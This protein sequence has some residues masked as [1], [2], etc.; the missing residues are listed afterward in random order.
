M[1]LRFKKLKKNCAK[2]NVYVS[3]LSILMVVVISVSFC[4]SSTAKKERNE[5]Q[6]PVSSG[7]SSSFDSAS[8]GA[9]NK[10]IINTDSGDSFPYDLNKPDE[11]Y[12]LPKYLTEISGIAYYKEN[13]ILCEQDQN[14]DI[15]VFNLN[16]KEIVNKYNFG[17]NGDY[18][19]IAVVGKTVYILRSDGKI[20][21]VEEFDSENRKVTEH[22]TPLSNNNNT[23]GLAYDKSSSSLLIA[24]K[25]SPAIYKKNQYSG[26][27]AIYRFDLGKMKLREEP[28]FLIDL[29]RPE[30]YMNEKIFKK[31]SGRSDLSYKLLR[32]STSLMPSGLT[33]HPFSDEIYLISSVGKILVV[34]NR[35][36]K[37]LDFQDL[38][39][40]IFV[41]PEGICFSPEGDL[42]I[43]SE[44]KGGQGYILKFKLKK[45]N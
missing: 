3:T 1:I 6:E 12:F 19:D 10:G 36:G 18:E 29:A 45:T 33:F 7:S 23:E 17:K 44:G 31:Y 41:Q 20:F 14:A 27:R 4:N 5:H 40:K 21:E 37:V 34:L 9:K 30:S 2:W 39:S 42:F 15:Y 38:D 11:R 28:D 8:Y 24:C 43:S 22:K 13:K 26:Y 25:G 35:Q 16:K 32:N